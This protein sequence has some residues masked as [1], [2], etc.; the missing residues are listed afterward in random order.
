MEINAQI[1]ISSF[2]I[3]IKERNKEAIEINKRL[4][5]TCHVKLITPT[6]G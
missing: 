6:N 2:D 1:D 5:K 4:I 3:S